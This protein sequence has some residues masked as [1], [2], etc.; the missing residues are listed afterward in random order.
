[1]ILDTIPPVIIPVGIRDG[2]NAAKLRSIRFSVTDNTEEIL[3]FTALLDGE[4]LRFSNDKGRNFVY[5]FDEHCSPGEHELVVIA[6][7]L[8][9]NKT[10]KRFRFTK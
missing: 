3:Q 8:A 10:E 4:W 5:E 7:D 9:G 6:E 2:M 1:M